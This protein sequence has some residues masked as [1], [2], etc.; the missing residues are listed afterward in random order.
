MRNILGRLRDRYDRTSLPTSS[1][2]GTQS[3]GGF[4]VLD[5]ETTG[6]FPGGHDRVIELAVVHVSP[7]GTIQGEWD[8]LVNPRRDLG[9]PSI[10]H[11]KAADILDAPTFEQIA[12]QLVELLSGRVLVAH[13]ARFDSGFLDAEFTRIGY[14]SEVPVA[15]LCTMKLAA[16]ILPGAA[17]RKRPARAGDDVRAR[18]THARRITISFCSTVARG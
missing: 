15:V 18:S 9:K 7:D 14:G 8:T 3:A 16:D 1:D 17:V 10:H 2:D 4:A 6:L 5:F 11:I 12:P 13:N